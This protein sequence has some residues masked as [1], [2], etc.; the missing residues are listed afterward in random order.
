V[1]ALVVL[2]CVLGLSGADAGVF[3]YG[4][5]RFYGSDAGPGIWP[6]PVVEIAASP[7]GRGYALLVSPL[8]VEPGTPGRSGFDL[9]RRN[10]L[11]SGYYTHGGGG[12]LTQAQ[13]YL[14][15]GEQTDGGSVA[16]YEAADAELQQIQDHCCNGVGSGLKPTAPDLADVA[17]ATA[18]LN[19]FFGT[20]SFIPGY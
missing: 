8:A 12:G 11:G 2:A 6:E 17:R 15:R 19:V 5:A 9:A 13:F 20:P 7:G 14:R 16:A 4:T 10:Y 1:A 3:A 18:E